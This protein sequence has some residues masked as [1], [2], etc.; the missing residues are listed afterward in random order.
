MERLTKK[1]NDYGGYATFNVKDTIGKLGKIEDIEQ[2][3]GIPLE[4]LFKAL[5]DGIYRFY[6]EPE[7]EEKRIYYPYPEKHI[8]YLDPVICYDEWKDRWIF[9]DDSR[10]QFYCLKDYG[11]TWALTREELEND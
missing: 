4:V 7:D 1:I 11:K 3:L 6:E 5:K 9:Y 8:Y 2:E 10:G